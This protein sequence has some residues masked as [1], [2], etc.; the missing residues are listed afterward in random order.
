MG[1][2]RGTINTLS[3]VETRFA[4]LAVL[5]FVLCS[6]YDLLL[7]AYVFSRIDLAFWLIPTILCCI[8]IGR[9]LRCLM[10]NGPTIGM[11]PLAL[12]SL[13]PASIAATWALTPLYL[14][15]ILATIVAVFSCALSA[16][17]ACWFDKLADACHRESRIANDAVLVVL[18]GRI[19]DGVPTLTIQQRLKVAAD[20][21]KESPQR[22]ILVT[23]GDTPDGST[24]E[25]QSM[26]RWLVEV[27]GVSKT[28]ILLEPHADD[29]VENIVFS[30]ELLREKGLASRQFCIVTSNYHLYRALEI[31][32]NQGVEAVGVGAPVPAT[33]SWQQWCREVMVSRAKR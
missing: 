2:E 4:R 12:F 17:F 22:T 15:W 31:A 18:G 8:V 25:A 26:Y 27:E 13:A 7:L 16:Y 9:N 29:T 6:A 10:S 21:W 5:L 30:S 1:E 11:A 23:G 33:S 3:A 20:L 14:P 32:E 19:R 28:A 24:T